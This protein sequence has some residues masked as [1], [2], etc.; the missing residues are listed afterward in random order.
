MRVVFHIGLNKTG[1]SSLQK[2][3]SLNPDNL[4]DQGWLYPQ[5]GSD[6]VAHHELFH[7]A[8]RG[9]G[10]LKELRDAIEAEAEAAGGKN[11][12]LSTEALH[13]TPHV[14]RIAEAFEGCEV[15]IIIFL[16]DYIDYLSSWYRED[17]QSSALCSDFENYAVL[18]RKPFV[19][20]LKRWEKFFGRD[21][22][23]IRDYNRQVLR[24]GSSIDEILC[25]IL[26][27]ESIEGWNTPGYENNP[28]VSGNLLFF[29]RLMNN[30]IP[31]DEASTYGS[32]IM[33]LA[34]TDPTFRQPMQISADF[35]SYLIGSQYAADLNQLEGDYGFSL[36]LKP[37]GREGSLI[38]DLDRLKSDYELIQETC[39]E[40]DFRFGDRLAQFAPALC[41]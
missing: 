3:L 20:I 13:D 24:N 17:V 25:G 8:H 14:G 39:R 41:L 10:P 33:D 31:R 34:K 2:F 26:R 36:S 9:I 28:S 6:G 38:P 37:P 29:K 11:V 12:L 7:A 15:Q 40:Q 16:R 23:H 32:E 30:F 19:P 4:A 21:A 27:I 18:K 22:L 5:A 35:C 1:T